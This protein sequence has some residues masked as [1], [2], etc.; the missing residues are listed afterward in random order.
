MSLHTLQ[1]IREIEWFHKKANGEPAD[2]LPGGKNPKEEKKNRKAA[3]WVQDETWYLRDHPS[4]KGDKGKKGSSGAHDLKWRRTK[5]KF[6]ILV[7]TYEIALM[8]VEELNEIRWRYVTCQLVIASLLICLL[9]PFLPACYCQ[10]L[11]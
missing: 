2:G 9:L 10:S 8:D 1:S 11:C 4:G 6:N 7:T 3:G 5:T